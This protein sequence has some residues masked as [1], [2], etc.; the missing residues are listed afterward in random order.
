MSD[1]ATYAPGLFL[2]LSALTLALLSPGPSILAILAVSLE[3]GRAP[4]LAM[5]F[6]VGLGSTVW[7]ILTVV[8]LSALIAV[9]ATAL[10][11][12]K[13]IG[14]LY[15]LWLGLTSFRAAVKPFDAGQGVD[16]AAHLS[17]PRYFARGLA[18]HLTNP[19]AAFAW[20][21]IAALG[22]QPDAP[23]WVGGTLIIGAAILSCSINAA[24]A[25]A[26][27]TRPIF[28]FYLRARR[29]IQCALGAF[30]TYAGLRLI[31]NRS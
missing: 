8:G 29:S 25:L 18:I 23:T 21:S 17:R 11:A 13:I 12:I 22:I 3:R 14:G 2:S 24:Y 28:D 9:S 1:I 26:F 16:P 6:G 10:T 4:A 15:L 19:K 20:V 31:L 7:A 30:F 27:S 5:A